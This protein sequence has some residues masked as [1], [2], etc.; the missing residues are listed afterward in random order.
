MDPPKLLSGKRLAGSFCDKESSTLIGRDNESEE[1]LVSDV[2]HDVEVYSDSDI[3]PS[4][5]KRH[6]R[7]DSPTAPTMQVIKDKGKSTSGHIESLELFNFM[8]HRHLLIKLNPHI[9]FIFGNNG[10]GKSAI[11]T[12]LTVALGGRASSTQRA[13]NVDNL[14]REG[15][16]HGRVRVKLFNGGDSPFQPDQ[17]GEHIVLE[18][19]FRRGGA[20][21]YAI[22][23][24]DGRLTTGKR[25]EINVICDHFGIQVDN[26]LAVLTQETA[27]RFLANAKPKELYEF[28]LKATQLERLYIDYN[29]VMDKIQTSTLKLEQSKAVLFDSW[30]SLAHLS[31]QSLEPLKSSILRLE[32]QL[33]DLERVKRAHQRIQQ[34]R[35]QLTWAMIK[36]CETVLCSRVA[37]SVNQIE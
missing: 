19:S 9:N 28:F 37:T 6:C 21:S 16:S 31:W 24:A 8:C 23:R 25:E 35:S 27:K 12:A 20:N 34:L 14:I 5:A 13:T 18:R 2:L 1:A 17:Y 32:R 36:E 33:A 30:S 10:S 11:L 22:S 7:M 26:P 3:D 15:A 4:L 29:Y